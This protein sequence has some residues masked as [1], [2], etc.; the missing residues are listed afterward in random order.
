MTL[1]NSAFDWTEFVRVPN[2]STEQLVTSCDD[3]FLKTEECLP[4]MSYITGYCYFAINKKLQCIYCK[5]RMTCND[6]DAARLNAMLNAQPRQ[7]KKNAQ[8]RQSKKN[9]QPRQSKKNAQPRQSK[10][11]AQPR[12]STT[13]RT[14]FVDVIQMLTSLCLLRG[15]AR[16]PCLNSGSLAGSSIT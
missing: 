10:K 8:P 2:D 12:Q 1:T 7:S 11:N 14:S 15:V 3:D 6:R 9:A 4:V 16:R 5:S 13:T